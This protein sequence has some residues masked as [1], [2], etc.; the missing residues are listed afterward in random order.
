MRRR[1]AVGH[2]SPATLWDVAW[3][4]ARGRGW[5]LCLRATLFVVAVQV[6][7]IISMALAYLLVRWLR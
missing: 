1:L 7:P 4:L 5:Q 6:T 3:W 2:R